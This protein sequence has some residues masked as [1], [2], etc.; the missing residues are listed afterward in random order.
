[1]DIVSIFVAVSV[2]VLIFFVILLLI[3]KVTTKRKGSQK[4]KKTILTAGL[5]KLAQNPNDV[6]A[7]KA[8]GDI[9]I[10]DNN[11]ERAFSIYAS[12]F[13]RSATFPPSEQLDINLKYGL[14]ALKTN[15]I[16]EAKE[17]FLLAR[18]IN[19]SD[20]QINY[21]LAYVH[22]LEKKYDK[23]VPLFRQALI[24]NE[25]SQQAKKHLALAYIK[26]KKYNDAIPFLKQV[27]Q[28]S[29]DDKESLFAIGQCFFEIGMSDNALKI[30]S[31]LRLDATFGAE[32]SLYCG[33]IYMKASQYEKA[34]KNFE[35][36]LKHPQIQQEIQNELRYLYA[37]SCI[38]L[39][40]I[41]KALSL[42]KEL[43]IIS[44]SYKDVPSLISKY[45]ELHQN[46]A[47]RTY[48]MA[49]QSEFVALCRKIVAVFFP[50]ARIKIIDVVVLT[51]HS[52]IVASID[53]DRF[54]DTALFRFFRSQ[55]S[56]GEL[57]LRDFHERAKELKAGTGVCCSA[58]AFTEEAIRFSEGRPIELYDKARLNKILSKIN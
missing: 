44:P 1:M 23:A 20:F 49:G 7:L 21:N 36:G 46:K 15:R 58:G 53:I 18:T 3:S 13:A 57:L 35:I 8:V 33:F 11:W 52:D 6:S 10:E 12:L 34:C 54:T 40:D 47:L 38:K 48:L 22:Y 19:Q 9:Y 31:K 29:P 24:L 41:A 55:G 37:Q 17:G 32:S 39:K 42:L 5:K 45:Q 26:L 28:I 2:V 51:T 56:V 4:S 27:L 43:Q 16:N 30:F 25:K 14:S 50:N